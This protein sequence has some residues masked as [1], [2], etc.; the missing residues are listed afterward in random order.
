MKNK[1]VIG[2]LLSLVLVLG[3]ALPGYAC[4][5]HGYHRQRQ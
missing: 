5:F 1:K 3:V 4:H 2:L